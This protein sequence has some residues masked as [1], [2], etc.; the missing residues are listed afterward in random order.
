MVSYHTWSA[1]QSAANFGSP[2]EFL[3]ERWL[4]P[5]SSEPSPF[6]ADIKD[7]FGPF[8]VGRNNCLG[9][10]L[11]YAELR[12]ILGRLL[13]N[14]DL[15]FPGPLSECPNWREQKM[16]MLMEKAPLPIR[17]TPVGR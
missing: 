2:H 6:A 1:H 10:S 4:A 5:S 8:S 7:A 3:P 15:E 14:F 9:K 16:F 13:W 11:A 12:L 17:L